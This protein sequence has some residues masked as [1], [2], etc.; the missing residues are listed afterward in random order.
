MTEDLYRGAI[1]S[2]EAAM[3]EWMKDRDPAILPEDVWKAP[4]DCPLWKMGLSLAQ[5]GS[6]YVR[7]KSGRYS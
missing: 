4:S 2:G 7:A 6:I 3:R 5:A 1:E